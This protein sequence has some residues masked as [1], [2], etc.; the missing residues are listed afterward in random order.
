MD[1]SRSAAGAVHTGLVEL[2]ASKHLRSAL[3]SDVPVLEALIARSGMELSKGYYSDEQAAAIT[4][5]SR[6]R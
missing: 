4:R 5:H 1:A 6:V 3:Q 2:V